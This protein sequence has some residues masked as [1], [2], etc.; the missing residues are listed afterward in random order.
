MRASEQEATTV[1]I[2]GEHFERFCIR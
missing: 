2:L 1:D